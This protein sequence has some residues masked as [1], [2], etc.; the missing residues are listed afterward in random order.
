MKKLEP[1]PEIDGT[2]R[3][4]IER[5]LLRENAETARFELCRY[6]RVSQNFAAVEA[7]AEAENF[8]DGHRSTIFRCMQFIFRPTQIRAVTGQEDK[9][10]LGDS[11]SRKFGEIGTFLDQG[12]IYR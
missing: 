5:A 4:K 12:Q 1:W 7:D 9:A 10:L 2:R 3:L 11:F 6:F 8:S